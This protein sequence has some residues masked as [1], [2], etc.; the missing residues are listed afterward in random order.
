MKKSDKVRSAVKKYFL[1]RK[2]Q[3]LLWLIHITTIPGNKSFDKN[4]LIIILLIILNT[5]PNIVIK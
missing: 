4:S 5:I 2:N 3:Q 1:K